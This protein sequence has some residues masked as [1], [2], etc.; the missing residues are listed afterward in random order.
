VVKVRGSRFEGSSVEEVISIKAEVPE[1]PSSRHYESVFW[2][3]HLELS[4]RQPCGSV[5]WIYLG[6]SLG[7][8]SSC[9]LLLWLQRWFV[10]NT[11]PRALA[12]C[13]LLRCALFLN[14]VAEI[15]RPTWNRGCDEISLVPVMFFGMRPC[16]AWIFVSCCDVLYPP[17]NLGFRIRHP[18]R[19]LS[20]HL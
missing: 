1:K 5:L 11:Q 13:A 9:H 18:V 8:P 19:S 15:R 4:P 10:R 3:Q 20:C 6:D 7:K 2:Y 17:A 16:T 14:Q 12:R